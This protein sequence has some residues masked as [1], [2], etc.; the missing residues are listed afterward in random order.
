MNAGRRGGKTFV[1]SQLIPPEI[2]NKNAAAKVKTGTPR[3]HAS[4]RSRLPSAESAFTISSP[5]YHPW[6]SRLNL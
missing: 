2:Q 5:R 6:G 3:I 4:A 1:S